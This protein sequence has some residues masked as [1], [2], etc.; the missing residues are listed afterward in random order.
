M[1]VLY[2][3]DIKQSILQAETMQKHLA[4]FRQAQTAANAL[5]LLAY[6]DAHPFAECICPVG[7]DRVLID[8]LRLKRARALHA[9]HCARP[10]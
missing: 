10:A 9:V 6:L 2:P 1:S 7:A 5:R 4:K 3:E 8:D